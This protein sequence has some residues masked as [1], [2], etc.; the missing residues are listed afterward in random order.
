MICVAALI[1]FSVL[2]LFS[3]KYRPL[4]KEA[5][6]CV[7]LKLRLRPCNSG[8]DKRVRMAV[9]M[10]F[11]KRTPRFAKFI[12]DYFSVFSTLFV[13]LTVLSI[14]YIAW[15]GYNYALYGNCNGPGSS[16]FCV[17]DPNGAGSSAVQQCTATPQVP[18]A[19]SVPT[20][21]SLDGFKVFN[22]GQNTTVD[23]FGCFAC[24]Y[25]RKAAPALLDAIE[26]RKDVTFVLVDFPLPQ[27]VNSTV[28]ANAANC[29]YDIAP[30]Q[31]ISYA[32]ELYTANL[33]IGVPDFNDSRFATCL[34]NGTQSRVTKGIALGK[35]VGIYG[36]PTYFIDGTAYVGPLN[37]RALNTLIDRAKK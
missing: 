16:G 20:P 2:A 3:A 25:T 31:Y 22:P 36:T 32:R 26:A 18:E 8:L 10:P 5:Y 27:H 37:S 4:A 11:I 12:Y 35:L 28:A 19:L 30:N 6:S 15:G 1:V 34:A 21:E 17:F 13:I 14:G 23:F 7:F 29:V 9:M 33:S 24:P